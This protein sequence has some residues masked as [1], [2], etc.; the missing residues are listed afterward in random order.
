MGTDQGCLERSKDGI[1]R[2]R[3]E[4]VEEHV[5]KRPRVARAE[6]SKAL[7]T[8]ELV[9]LH[10]WINSLSHGVTGGGDCGRGQRFCLQGRR[11]QGG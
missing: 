3:V 7:A 9:R 2:D 8:H 5:L 11:D 4:A 6:E 1:R 10:V